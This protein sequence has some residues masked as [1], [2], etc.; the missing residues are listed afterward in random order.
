MV[1]TC[2]TVHYITLHYITLHYI[3]LQERLASRDSDSTVTTRSGQD[4]R[5]IPYP[6]A[7]RHREKDGG[8]SRLARRRRVEAVREPRVARRG[9]LG[10]G[11]QVHLA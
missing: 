1:K 10:A 8:L 6:C 5:A 3:A 2:I 4:V 7:T 11:V 9:E